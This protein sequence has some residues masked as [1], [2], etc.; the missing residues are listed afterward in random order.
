MV[1]GGGGRGRLLSPGGTG[2]AR[3]G[4]VPATGGPEA[5]VAGEGGGGGA[6]G[7]VGIVLPARGALAAA[8]HGGGGGDA[9]RQHG[10]VGAEGGVAKLPETLRPRVHG[11]TGSGGRRWRRIRKS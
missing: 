10:G 1:V 7:E 5:R 9:G 8:E 3:G 4:A 11:A 2:G 6:G